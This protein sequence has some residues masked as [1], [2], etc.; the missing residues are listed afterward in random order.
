[1]YLIQTSGDFEEGETA[2]LLELF[3]ERMGHKD[4]RYRYRYRYR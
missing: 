4:E 1:L 2:I 3:M